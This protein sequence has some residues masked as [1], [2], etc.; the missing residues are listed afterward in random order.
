MPPTQEQWGQL[1]KFLCATCGHRS[2]R[3][4]VHRGPCSQC[5][6]E[7]LTPIC[8]SF[9]LLEQDRATADTL[10]QAMTV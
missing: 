2:V 1:N 4:F 6:V 7:C 9:V 5:W 10:L 8:E 3:H